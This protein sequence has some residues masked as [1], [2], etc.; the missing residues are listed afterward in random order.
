MAVRDIVEF[1]DPRL[2]QPAAPV[3]LFDARLRALAGDLLD[4]LYSA[5]GIGLSAPQLG[6]P[7]QVMVMDLSGEASA[8]EVYVNPQVQLRGRRC[9]VEET[10]LSLPGMK[11]LV[12]R[13]DAVRVRALDATGAPFERDLEGLHAVCV[14]HEM[15]HLAGRVFLDRLPAWQRWLVR[16]MAKAQRRA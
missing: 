6:E 16:R 9:L 3:A 12:P 14:Q 8:P 5:G 2:Q 15:D 10:C 4:T 1:P 7:L 11:A 13:V